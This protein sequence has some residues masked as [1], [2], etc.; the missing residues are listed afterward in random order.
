MKAM[1]EKKTAEKM[2]IGYLLADFRDTDVAFFRGQLLTQYDRRAFE[3]YCYVYGERMEIFRPWQDGESRWLHIAALDAD[4]AAQAIRRAGLDVLVDLS[5]YRSE[6]AAEILA[7]RPAKLQAGFVGAF[8]S[9]RLKAVTYLLTDK[10][11][12]PPDQKERYFTERLYWLPQTHFCYAP[13]PADGKAAGGARRKNDCVTFGSFHHFTQLSDAF[14]VLWGRILQALPTARLIL[15]SRIFGSGYGC[16]E[17]RHRLRRLGFPV[18]R[19]SLRA[20]GAALARYGDV[21]ILLDT[22]PRQAAQ[23]ICDALYMGAVPVALAGKRH[24]LRLSYALLKNAGLEECVA[25]DEESYVKRAIALADNP[26]KLRQVQKSLRQRLLKSPLTDARRFA[27]NVERAYREMRRR[28]QEEARLPQVRAEALSLLEA[29]EEGLLY[30]M[31]RLD[32]SQDSAMVGRIVGDLQQAF[33]RLAALPERA[34]RLAVCRLPAAE[35][36]DGATN[37][38]RFYARREY[39]RACAALEQTLLPRVRALASLVKGEAAE[40]Q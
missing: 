39:G 20:P 32:A 12:D 35:L 9:Y 30:V 24:H 16:Q 14:L 3:L 13:P 34:P 33:R 17:T 23:H 4:L 15:E 40:R 28:Q 21:D 11:C 10:Y 37:L 5:G 7:R 31:A 8:A 27:G 38:R 25:F 2:K 6:R 29:A 18:E 36:V 22:Y 19:V 26:Y 1:D